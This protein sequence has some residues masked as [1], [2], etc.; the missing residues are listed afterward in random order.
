MIHLTADDYGMHP[1]INRGIAYCAEQGLIDGL[2][3]AASGACLDD[4]PRLVAAHPHLRVGAHLMLVGGRPLTDGKRMLV[5]NGGF[6]PDVFTLARAVGRGAGGSADVEREWDAQIQRLVGLGIRLTHVNSH[7]HAHLLPG[8]WPAMFRL[9]QRHQIEWIRSSY[10]SVWGAAVKGSPWLLGHQ[11]LAK[12]RYGSL[13]ALKRAKTLGM[14]CSTAFTASAVVDRLV[15]ETLAGRTVE[16]MV[17]PGFAT[18]EA[19]K[20]F[21]SWRPHWEEEIQELKTLQ[22]VIAL[23]QAHKPGKGDG[24]WLAAECRRLCAREP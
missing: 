21:P 6:A 9:A 16:V 1:D 19:K 12:V 18:V 3:A 4:L 7:Q 20:A 8:L 14:L 15:T 13:P 5:K 17:H 22:P 2:S 10:E 24:G 11:V 23:L